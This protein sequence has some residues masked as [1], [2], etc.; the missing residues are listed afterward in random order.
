MD[1]GGASDCLARGLDPPDPRQ[2]EGLEVIRGH[3]LGQDIPVPVG[4]EP[5]GRGAVRTRTH[6]R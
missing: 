3:V 6:A 2:G 5:W 4:G 1:V